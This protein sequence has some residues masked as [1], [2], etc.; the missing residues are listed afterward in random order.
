MRA[1]TLVTSGEVACSLTCAAGAPAHSMAFDIMSEYSPRG[2]FRAVGRRYRMKSVPASATTP[3]SR[4][5]NSA[6]ARFA[7]V[8]PKTKVLPPIT[9][10]RT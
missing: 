8:L 5:E 6:V 1:T 7:S 10:A 9:C 4:I 2:P 3:V